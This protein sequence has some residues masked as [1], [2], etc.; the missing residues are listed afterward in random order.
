MDAQ[1]LPILEHQN[2]A[3]KN[4]ADRL[5][6]VRPGA[7]NDLCAAIDNNPTLERVIGDLQGRERTVAL[8]NGLRDEHRIR[9][10]P[11]L[12]A[13]RLVTVWNRLEQAQ[14]RTDE[15]GRRCAGAWKRA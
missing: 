12:R 6:A 8:V 5:D 13:E 10:D 3:L 2:R 9:Q 4:A 15:W 1:G 14:A 11:N 7:A